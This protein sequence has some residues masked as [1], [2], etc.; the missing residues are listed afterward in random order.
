MS[1]FAKL[2]RCE[3]ALRFSPVQ[4]PPHRVVIARAKRVRKRL[5]SVFSSPMITASPSASSAALAALDDLPMLD[6]INGLV[7][8]VTSPS[9]RTAMY[10]R[11][12]QATLGSDNA[13]TESD[14]SSG[15]AGG[16]E[17]KRLAR[18]GSSI[19]A[20][21]DP[22]RPSW[23]E[24]RQSATSMSNSDTASD[25][26]DGDDIL[27]T[28]LANSVAPP[29]AEAVDSSSSVA[30]SVRAMREIIL[31]LYFESLKTVKNRLLRELAAND[32]VFGSPTCIRRCLT[33]QILLKGL[34]S[35]VRYPFEP[36]EMTLT[37]TLP[38]FG[39][40]TAF[41]PGLRVSDELATNC[42]WYACGE[43]NN[44]EVHVHSAVTVASPQL[45]V[46]DIV[47]ED[48]ALPAAHPHW[49]WHSPD[50]EQQLHLTRAHVLELCTV[51]DLPQSCQGSPIH[52]ALAHELVLTITALVSG[53]TKAARE[54]RDGVGFGILQ[55]MLLSCCSGGVPPA[56]L[57]AVLQLAVGG[58]LI[59]ETACLDPSQEPSTSRLNPWT[60]SSGAT[61]PCLN[62]RKIVHPEAV[63]ILLKMLPR[64]ATELQ[65]F[66]FAC[67]TRLL[68]GH[69]ASHLRNL[70]TLSSVDS[71]SSILH[72]LLDLLSAIPDQQSI[73]IAL[74]A[75]LIGYS[76]TT[77]EVNLILRMVHSDAIPSGGR[78]P[79]L[80]LSALQSAIEKP[81]CPRRYF[82]LNGGRCGMQL[83][84]RGSSRMFSPG[85]PQWSTT[86]FSFFTWLCVD[87]GL[88]VPCPT[89]HYNTVSFP[90]AGGADGTEST[91]HILCLWDSK[92]R[93]FDLYL[94]DGELTYTCRHASSDPQ[95]LRT[96]FVLRTGVWY[97]IALTHGP[98]PAFTRTADACVYVDG[99]LKGKAPMKS[100]KMSSDGVECLL[101]CGRQ[102]NPASVS[103]VLPASNAAHKHRSSLIGRCGSVVMLQTVL[104]RAQINAVCAAG[105]DN[106][107]RFKNSVTRAGQFAAGGADSLLS[108]LDS[109]V[110][111]SFN[112]G[113]S[114]NNMF[115]NTA[116]TPETRG[117]STS[118]YMRAFGG[119]TA[120][121]TASAR[122]VFVSMG[123]VCLLLPL[124]AVVQASAT[125]TV[126]DETQTDAIACILHLV[127]AVLKVNS[128]EFHVI[129]SPNGSCVLAYLLQQSPSR[130][131]TLPAAEAVHELSRLCD[132]QSTLD[133]EYKDGL[134]RFLL[135]NF[136]IWHHA[137]E[138]ALVYICQTLSQLAMTHPGR[139][140]RVLG[141]AHRL[142]GIIR[143]VCFSPWSPAS[144]V[145]VPD[146]E[147]PTPHTAAALTDNSKALVK[148]LLLLSAQYLLKAAFVTPTEMSESLGE[149]LIDAQECDGDVTSHSFVLDTLRM[150]LEVARTDRG[151]ASLTDAVFPV[152]GFS[153][154][155]QASLVSRE[156]SI[157]VSLSACLCLHLYPLSILVN[158]C[159]LQ[160]VD[161]PAPMTTPQVSRRVPFFSPSHYG[162]LE[163]ISRMPFT[164][165]DSARTHSA[166][167]IPSVLTPPKSAF[168]KHRRS[169]LDSQANE[170]GQGLATVAKPQVDP[171]TA[172]V[173]R[174]TNYP[175]SL[176]VITRLF[177]GESH[178]AASID[179]IA[180]HSS[181]MF[182]DP[183][184]VAQFGPFESLWS[185]GTHPDWTRSSCRPQPRGWHH[186]GRISPRRC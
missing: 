32:T 185:I 41:L 169:R 104:S 135:F 49:K 175:C 99:V 86:G 89:S 101:G 102:G 109:S 110:V 11:P 142:L 144:P 146:E 79:W 60:H 4:L 84:K 132:E 6:D 182:V 143:T 129:L 14:V 180:R 153:S 51:L 8:T 107:F 73:T 19:T 186:S 179:A 83:V 127:T 62:P 113:L 178:G 61:I 174:V 106:I 156:T 150:L 87:E 121:S 155:A 125:G 13:S 141:G 64:A 37:S 39:T 55:T 10:M 82:L 16:P 94:D 165:L 65:Q 149:L 25:A 7:P 163:G 112:P 45:S 91:R 170:D 21:S 145:V 24:K 124:F 1:L 134:Q 90:T 48:L 100:A 34:R 131:L 166:E 136:D 80:L 183:T 52:I 23:H 162:S 9:R 40:Q 176:A 140:W 123:G 67:L 54:F 33:L 92:G 68:H 57:F 53:N 139:C 15:G 111:F 30:V 59:P 50:K 130:L 70:C 122:D 157:L 148:K 77:S 29:P 161:I 43:Q 164:A 105:S 103:Q 81:A 160:S 58:D 17:E 126:D 35:Y 74:I 118:V 173:R 88:S 154:T 3:Q 147:P 108:D 66:A 114:F 152:D 56:I 46:Y 97:F 69:S 168:T 76:V 119:G 158:V 72:C 71:P 18:S 177:A 26:Y 98:F 63:V 75:D 138:A 116:Y 31:N 137:S 172:L 181:V 159:A 36:A 28:F 42:A 117:G 27:A 133:D 2:L 120:F 128:V 5:P 20:E 151:L 85:L 78:R 44:S 93:G 95:T 115:I 167:A 171:E 96:G 22:S 47:F 12:R 38:C 184:A